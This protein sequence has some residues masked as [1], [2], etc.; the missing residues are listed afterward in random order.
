M[1]QATCN[2]EKKLRFVDLLQAPITLTRIRSWSDWLGTISTRDVHLAFAV[3]GMDMK[4]SEIDDAVR[5][6]MGTKR[7][8]SIPLD[9]SFF[10]LQNS[11]VFWGL[12][13]LLLQMNLAQFMRVMVSQIDM[14]PVDE[15]SPSD[16]G[17]R[18]KTLHQILWVK[19]HTQTCHWTSVLWGVSHAVVL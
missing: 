3:L 14:L 9:L 10:G 13:F 8:V 12:W 11:D 4:R 2:S 5:E 6:I 16:S 7:T 18:P 19:S 1:I 17:L 15:Y